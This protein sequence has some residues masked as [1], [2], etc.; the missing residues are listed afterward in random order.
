MIRKDRTV[1]APVCQFGIQCAYLKNE[2]EGSGEP[3]RYHHPAAHYDRLRSGRSVPAASAAPFDPLVSRNKVKSFVA[4]V[5]P[6]VASSGGP[7]AAARTPLRAPAAS[8][9]APP[10]PPPS[11]VPLIVVE[12]TQAS[13]VRSAPRF[14]EGSAVGQ[15]GAGTLCCG[16]TVRTTD[17]NVDWLQLR[18]ASSQ[19]LPLTGVTRLPVSQRPRFF[20][21]WRGRVPLFS[22]SFPNGLH[23][24][25]AAL[26]EGAVLEVCA[27]VRG[28]GGM[29]YGALA[30]TH[31]WSTMDDGLDECACEP[32]AAAVYRVG[33]GKETLQPR[34]QPSFDARWKMAAGREVARG[35]VVAVT[36][37][38]RIEHEQKQVVM[39]RLAGDGGWLPEA[40]CWPLMSEP[41]RATF[42]ALTDLPVVAH[43]GREWWGGGS[44]ETG[45]LFAVDC[46]YQEHGR[47]T[48]GRGWV[49]VD[50]H[51]AE[52]RGAAEEGGH[53]ERGN[54][55]VV[56]LEAEADCGLLHG[57]S[58]H[59][60]CCSRCAKS[61][62]TCPVC[63]AVIDRVIAVF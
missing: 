20:R 55:C 25:A 22:S 47:L 42:A 27:T 40:L 26:P 19:W 34:S 24:E 13:S 54:M 51:S 63:R 44:V 50:E 4:A 14:S 8:H 2:V 18:G 7:S 59:R 43:P 36:H 58:V 60:C 49:A 9:A 23:G 35:S 62:T 30:H 38:L 46:I 6:P 53:E 11:E 56:C 15:L 3:C 29:V 12:L 37:R 45:A 52:R 16:L 31:E 1:I 21:A 32:E 48:D 17:G 57:D 41:G 5:P 39:L 33:G 61:V 28:R 10:P